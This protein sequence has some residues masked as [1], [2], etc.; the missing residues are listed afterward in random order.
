VIISP[1]L[2]WVEQEFSDV[3]SVLLF[4][5][6]QAVKH[7]FAEDEDAVLEGFRLREKEGSTG[8]VDGFAI[9][10]S[11]SDSILEA[12]VAVIKNKPTHPIIWESLDGQP[13]HIA[14]ALYVPARNVLK[15]HLKLLSQVALLLA[16]DDFTSFLKT[17]NDANEIVERMNS[18]IKLTD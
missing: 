6:S 4:L 18:S 2:V 17:N 7:N 12:K 3:H 10:H 16:N 11:Q 1:E 5:A 14:I 8:M 9:P 13:I 15:Q